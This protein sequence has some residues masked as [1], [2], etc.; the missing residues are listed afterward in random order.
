MNEG[1]VTSDIN[2]TYPIRSLILGL[3]FFYIC[4]K[5]HIA[6]SNVKF[7]REKHFLKTKNHSIYII[8]YFILV[9]WY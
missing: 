7:F 6:N 1:T 4:R 2:T 8:I 9:E 5:Y 3:N